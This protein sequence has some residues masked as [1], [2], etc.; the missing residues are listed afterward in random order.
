MKSFLRKLLPMRNRY[1]MA[2]DFL[3]ILVLPSA[4]FLLRT[5]SIEAY[6]SHLFPITILTLV[7]AALKL[8]VYYQMG[9]YAQYWPFA[10]ISEVATMIRATTLA[11]LLEMV[12][13]A[14]FLIPAGIIPPGFPRSVLFLDALFSMIFVIGFRVSISLMFTST[15]KHGVPLNQKAVLIVGAGDAGLMVGRELLRN[16]HLGLNPV[17]YIDDDPLK[18]GK[19]ING[20]RVFGTVA[21][22]PAILGRISVEEVI[23]AIPSAS[24]KLMREVVQAC[25]ACGVPSRTIPALMDILRGTAR[26]EQI[27]NVQLEDLLRRGT[28]RA[29]SEQVR[30]ILH[31]SRVLVT[32]A[33]GSIGSEICRQ[34]MDFD[35]LEL[36]L[37]GH[38]ETSIYNILGE[39]RNL[40]NKKTTVVPVIGDIRDHH[41]MQQV[42]S[43]YRPD[44]VFHAAAHKHLPL[45]EENLEDAVTNNILGTS[46]LVDL[47]ATFDTDRFVMISTDK[48][49]NPTSI[50]GVTKRIAELIVRDAGRRSRKRFVTVR[51]GN[52]LGSRGSVVPL[53]QRQI[54]MGGP[55][56]VADQEVRRFFMTIPEAVQ[57][58]LQSASMGYGGEVFVLDMGEQIR[59]L[60]IARDLLRLNGL[61]EGKDIDIVF[62]GLKPGE[63][64]CE[65]LFFKNE[66]VEKTEHDKILVCRNGHPEHGLGENG[67]SSVAGLVLKALV[68]AAK[69]GNTKEIYCTLKKLVPE[70]QPPPVVNE[71]VG[72]TALI[73]HAIIDGD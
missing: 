42:F 53:F 29:D 69:D 5:E 23:V 37:L 38:G 66:K 10:G 25:K 11:A 31:C 20:I 47:A 48:A 49:V 32:G 44:V 22:L 58:V 19:R 60:D 52:V 18:I 7:M 30:D 28:V 1:L 15:S 50:L 4:A 51:F 61:E 16:S 41:R 45:M 54:C 46:T 70:Y 27:R 9:M 8:C 33:G 35:P 64:L 71:H 40:P 34:V 13:C 72:P 59:I 39:L 57:L 6:Q 62:S 3:G 26:V 68:M 24:G 17:G 67:G 36:V 55:L 2:V 65:E 12:V 56:T 43:R 63:K 21:K 73:S 14:V